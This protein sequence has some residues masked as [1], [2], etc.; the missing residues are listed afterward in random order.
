MVVTAGLGEKAPTLTLTPE[1]VTLENVHDFS[2]VHPDTGQV[3]FSTSDPELQLPEGL[4][5]LEAEEVEVERI[6][7][8]L[9]EDLRV[10]SDANLVVRGAEGVEVE[11]HLEHQT[12]LIFISDRWLLDFS[13]LGQGYHLEERGGKYRAVRGVHAGLGDAAPRGRRLRGR[14]RPVQALRLHAQRDAL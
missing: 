9:G 6:T 8:P 2:V 3:L 11:S 10:R 4:E 1:H 7:A 5:R 13:E 12:N 14:D